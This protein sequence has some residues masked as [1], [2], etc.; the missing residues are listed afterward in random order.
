MKNHYWEFSDEIYSRLKDSSRGNYIS[1]L[2][3]HPAV[4]RRISRRGNQDKTNP[5]THESGMQ[6]TLR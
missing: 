2:E 4:A 6:A 3:D 1:Y 5:F